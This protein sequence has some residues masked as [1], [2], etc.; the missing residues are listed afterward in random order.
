MNF[1]C[2]VHLFRKQRGRP[3]VIDVAMS[4]VRNS[5][6]FFQYKTIFPQSQSVLLGSV[7]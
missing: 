4:T 7:E 1:L 6:L 3:R 2:S 5:G